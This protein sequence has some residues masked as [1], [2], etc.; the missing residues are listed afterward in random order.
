MCIS[1]SEHAHNRSFML[2]VVVAQLI[3]ACNRK[4]AIAMCL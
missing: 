2:A 4:F 3:N 1:V